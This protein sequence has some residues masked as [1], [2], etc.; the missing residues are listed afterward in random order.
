M[1]YQGIGLCRVS[2]SKQRLEGSSLSAQEVRIRSVATDM[3]DCTIVKMWSLDISSRKGKNLNRKDLHEMLAF[4][5]QNK[6]IKFVFVDE[7]DRFMRSVDEYYYWK[8]KFEQEAGTTFVIAAKPEL[9][10][11]PNTASMAIEFFGVWQGEVSNEERI[12]KTTDKMQAKIKEGYYP[13]HCHL[14]YTTS[15]TKGLHVPSEPQWSLLRDSMHKIL[16]KGYS[17]HEA[18]K[19]LNSN[20]FKYG[21]KELEMDKFKAALL[22]PYYAG[23]VRMSNWEVI[24]E[25]GLHKPMIT[26]EEHRLLVDK[27]SGLGKKFTVRKENPEF[28]INNIGMC[29]RCYKENGEK[30]MLVGYNHNNG[31]QGN[32][33]KHYKRYRCRLCNKA[34]LK[35]VVHAGFDD[36]LNDI[37][38]VAPQDRLRDDLKR[39]WREEVE[40]K[41]QAAARLKQKKNVLLDKK[42]K[43]VQA[44]VDQPEFAE[45]FKAS[46]LN[47]KTEILTVEQAI[48]DAENHDDEFEEFVDFAFGFVDNMRNEFWELDRED[49][50]RCKQLIFPGE[51]LVSRTGKVSTQELSPFYRYK[52]TPRRALVGSISYNGG[53]SGARTQD[54]GLKRPVL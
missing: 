19:W 47:L 20:G 2:T 21:E 39:I 28:P 38:F 24:N 25:H 43:L 50:Q 34:V 12:T 46:L 32:A 31:K 1:K 27:V 8:V 6:K 15:D 49:K 30:G 13:G 10:L 29:E 3:F 42:D 26:K 11:S 14:A 5:K 36:L 41:T 22:E 45:D 18:L 33:R 54:T 53:P 37:E 51:F 23:I 40:D 52:K 16:Y 48:D 7:H 4:C 35:D 9:A 17:V 44:I